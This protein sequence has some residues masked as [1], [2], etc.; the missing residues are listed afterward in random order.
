MTLDELLQLARCFVAGAVGFALLWYDW[1][2]DEAQFRRIVRE[3]IE[4][5]I[6]KRT[7]ENSTNQ[8]EVT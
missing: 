3:E 1:K 8:T 4:R 2:R 5:A 6:P 7:A